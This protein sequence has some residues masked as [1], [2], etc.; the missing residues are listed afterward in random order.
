MGK[1]S[2][3]DI[4][5]QYIKNNYL[6]FRF[7]FSFRKKG[8]YL[9][10]RFRPNNLGNTFAIFWTHIMHNVLKSCKYYV[11]RLYYK[12]I[13]FCATNYSVYY[14]DMYASK[15]FVLFGN[16]FLKN[17]LWLVPFAK[18][19]KFAKSCNKVIYRIRLN[20]APGFYFS[21]WVFG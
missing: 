14:Y 5:Y 15:H 11:N 1:N 17:I 21:F 20:A 13:C 16:H 10:T 7:F 4:K 18:Q 3:C 2:Q 8:I 12:F 6:H 19:F 9:A